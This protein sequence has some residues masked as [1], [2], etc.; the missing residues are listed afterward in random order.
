V[1]RLLF[2]TGRPGIGKTTVILNAA[3][4]LK[5]QGYV[6]GGMLSREVRQEGERVG[7]ELLDLNTGQKGWLA[8]MNQPSG[9]QISK[10]RVNL[11][12]LD[13][14]GAKAI[15]NALRNSEV[16]IIDE[17]G[18]M[19]LFSQAFK[20][21]IEDALD[22]GKLVLGVIH[23]N[24]RDPLIESIKKRDD[25]EIIEVTLRN[26]QELQ[27]LLIQKAL[28]FLKERKHSG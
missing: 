18:P 19:E 5:K 20:Q 15:Q 23:R 26:R 4:G 25:S 24:A 12:D 7:F 2:L 27:N 6:V 9:P 17:I 10:Y 8:H 28:Q 22:N 11:R 14:I 21:V 1:K 13:E 16:T 3:N